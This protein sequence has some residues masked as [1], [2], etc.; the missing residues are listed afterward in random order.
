MPK[1]ILD[2]SFKKLEDFLASYAYK[3]LL[4]NATFLTHLKKIHRKFHSLLILHHYLSSKPIWPKEVVRSRE[5]TDYLTETTSD[6]SQSIFSF[7]HGSYKSSFLLLRSAIENFVK[8]IGL[9]QGQKVLTITVVHDLLQVVSATDIVAKNASVK[10]N[11]SDLKHSYAA[12]CSYVHTSDKKF[13]TCVTIVGEHPTFKKDKGGEA[14]DLICKTILNFLVIL[15][16]MFWHD[17]KSGLHHTE[18]DLL[19][20]NLESEVKKRL[21]EK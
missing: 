3:S 7:C 8:V 11:Y 20:D 13:M 9:H 5:F 17:F 15:S 2:D 16:F 18:L 12:L 1:P 10:A 6:I 4:A 14:S 21:A 19:N